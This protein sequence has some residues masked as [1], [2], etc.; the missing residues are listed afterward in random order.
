MA[1]E[2]FVSFDTAKLLEKNGFY[3]ECPF[4]YLSDGNRYAHSEQRVVPN[5]RKVYDCPTQAMVMKWLREENDLAVVPM[6]YRY[7]GKWMVILVFLGEPKEKDDKFDMCEL[8]RK[9]TSYEEAAEYGIRYVVKYFVAEIRKL[10]MK[11][12]KEYLSEEG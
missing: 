8:R 10:R 1:K 11:K 12:L 6:P 7:P 4:Y 9:F 2:E 3:G 5:G